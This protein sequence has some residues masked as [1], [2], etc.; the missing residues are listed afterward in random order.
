MVQIYGD[1]WELTLVS[2]FFVCCAE[3]VKLRINLP[4]EGKGDH[5]VV[6]EVYARNGKSLPI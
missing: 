3:A 4:L 5:E 2:S 1:Q 6:D